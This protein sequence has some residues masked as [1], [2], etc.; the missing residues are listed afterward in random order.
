MTTSCACDGILCEKYL[1]DYLRSAENN[2]NN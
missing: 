1:C 2:L